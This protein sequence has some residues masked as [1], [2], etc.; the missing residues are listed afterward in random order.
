MGPCLPPGGC[1]SAVVRGHAMHTGRQRTRPNLLP[2][3]SGFGRVRSFRSACRW[4]GAQDTRQAGGAVLAA[5]RALCCIRDVPRAAM[6]SR[7]VLEP[8][9][10]TALRPLRHWSPGPCG[11]CVSCGSR[12]ARCQG[13]WNRPRMPRR[14]AFV[15]A[16]AIRSRVPRWLGASRRCRA[17]VDAGPRGRSTP[18]RK[19]GPIASWRRYRTLRWDERRLPRPMHALGLPCRQRRMPCGGAC[20]RVS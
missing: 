7:V 2:L 3:A 5:K 18:P 15:L 1:R 20:S 11:Y 9:S 19:C 8:R 6:P 4:A 10:R 14:P 16:R 17:R 12:G 13:T